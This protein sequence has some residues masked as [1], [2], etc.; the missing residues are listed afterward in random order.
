M[1]Y[2]EKMNVHR[3]VVNPVAEWEFEEQQKS[4]VLWESSVGYDYYSRRWRYCKKYFGVALNNVYA[5]NW[6]RK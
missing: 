1:N 3:F 2:K 5:G 6:K 4:R